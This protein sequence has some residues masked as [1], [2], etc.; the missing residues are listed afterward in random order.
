MT[1]KSNDDASTSRVHAIAAVVQRH[2]PAVLDDL[3]AHH[4][5]QTPEVA[6]VPC[7]F[8]GL[9]EKHVPGCM[10][11][12]TGT[13]ARSVAELM[14]RCLSD[15]LADQLPAALVQNAEGKC[16][17]RIVGDRCVED[18]AKVRQGDKRHDSQSRSIFRLVQLHMPAALADALPAALKR[19]LPAVLPD[20]IPAMLADVLP[21]I[22]PDILPSILPSLFALPTSFTSSYDSS[23][24]DDTPSPP[25]KGLSPPAQDH[26][27]S[28]NLRPHDL[29]A[30]GAT[31]LPHLVTHLRPQL[32][33]MHARSLARGV[34]YWQK[35]AFLDLEETV[36][37]YKG[38]LSRLRDNGVEELHREARCAVDGVREEA[39]GVAEEVEAEVCER[40]ED[41][42]RRRGD[43]VVGDVRRAIQAAMQDT[44]QPVRGAARRRGCRRT[45][46]GGCRGVGQ[47]RG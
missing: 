7:I 39:G 30:L 16:T 15:L 6:C 20:I 22:L 34:H 32:A 24:F 21:T 9:V 37:A 28:Y 38:E 14:E 43:K 27:T 35:T 46:K 18:E 31:L 26:L 17:E 11:Q 42:I 47:R 4:T 36:E 40:V 19:T 3:R 33:K 41:Q 25:P 44:E 45:G 29:T 8:C 2:L 5:K 23:S 12:D 13:D 10:F 1:V